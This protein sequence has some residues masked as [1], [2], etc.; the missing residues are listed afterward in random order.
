M[1]LVA[2]PAT[3]VNVASVARGPSKAAQL[4]SRSG[5]RRIDQKL[6]KY[7]PNVAAI[8]KWRTKLEVE[9]F[10]LLKAHFDKVPGGVAKFEPRV[11]E[12]LKPFWDDPRA[13]DL[14]LKDAD[15]LRTYGDYIALAAIVSKS[16]SLEAVR[17]AKIALSEAVNHPKAASPEEAQKVRE[18][19]AL[20]RQLLGDD[21]VSFTP[22]DAGMIDELRL[23]AIDTIEMDEAV[24]GARLGAHSS[25]KR[26]VVRFAPSPSRCATNG[27]DSDSDAT[28][29]VDAVVQEAFAL[30][31]KQKKRKH[32]RARCISD[33]QMEEE[34]A[35]QDE[36]DN[37]RWFGADERTENIDYGDAQAFQDDEE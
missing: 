3:G 28:A 27:S 30:A 13:S 22:D 6:H 18:L 17:A 15:C 11:R 25:K 1:A 19:L 29:D 36:R 8:T 37:R 32:K 5:F 33:A 21:V 24:L 20:G 34:M 9:L 31:D 7:V 23:D 16:H 2:T 14:G 12:A 4:L 10:H 26:K 35:K